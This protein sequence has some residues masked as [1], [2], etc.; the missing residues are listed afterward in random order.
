LPRYFIQYRAFFWLDNGRYNATG[1]ALIVIGSVF[2]IFVFNGLFDAIKYKAPAYSAWDKFLAVYGCACGGV[3][4]GLQDMFAD[5]FQ[6]S[7]KAMLQEL[8]RH[9]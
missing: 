5:I 9:Q 2:W 7:H 8:G 6:I 4:F 3:A 1:A